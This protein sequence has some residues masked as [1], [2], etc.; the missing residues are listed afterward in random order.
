MAQMSPESRYHRFFMAAAK[1]SE[2]QLRYLTEV[3]QQDH[4]A[5]VAVDPATPQQ[6][7]L[8]IARFVRSSADRSLAEMALT[9]IDAWQGKGLGTCLM[10]VLYLMART[11]GI[12]ALRGVVLPE[13][14]AVTHWLAELGGTSVLAGDH[15]EVDLR[16]HRDLSC[17]PETPEAQHL[18]R[19]IEELQAQL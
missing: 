18:R 6:R 2:G 11:R 14:R 9:V 8:G 19:A 3:D 15:K 10:G 1:L 5:W 7:G 12:R 4:V 16:V 13:N 17:L